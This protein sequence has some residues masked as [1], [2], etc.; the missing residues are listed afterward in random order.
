MVQIWS[1]QLRTATIESTFSEPQGLANDGK[2]GPK[3]AI[4]NW[5]RERFARKERAR[6]IIAEERL[7]SSDEPDAYSEEQRRVEKKA[8]ERFE[9]KEEAKRKVE[10]ELEKLER[11]RERNADARARGAADGSEDP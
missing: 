10:E 11:L 6:R 8:R 7:S 2:R 9:R 5:F 1:T 4:I 3:V